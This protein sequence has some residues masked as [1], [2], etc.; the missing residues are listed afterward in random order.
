MRLLYIANARIPTE[1]AHGL[2][3]MQN[4]EALARAGAEVTL[5]TPRRVNTPAL[6]AVADPWAHYGVHP[7]F[8]LQRLPCLD[9][10]WLVGE[11]IALLRRGAFLL[12]VISWLFV[13]TVT[14]LSGRRP[15][16]YYTRDL[17]VAGLVVLLRRGGRLAYE[18]HRISGS[19][20]GR[21]LQARVMR[22]AAALYPVTAAM[23][24]EAGK[25]GATCEQLCVVHDGIRAERFADMPTRETARQQLG[26]NSDRF[27]VGYVGRLQ[28]MAM[29]KGVGS[30]TKA[31]A[32]EKNMAI[33][34]VGGPEER[35][36]E[37]RNLWHACGRSDDDFLV[38]GQVNP[39][40]VPLHLA[41]FDVCA[42]PFPWTEHFAWYAS[43]VKLFEYMSSGRPLVA[44]DLPAVAEVVR[45]EEHAL[46]VPPDDIPAL[47][48]ALLRLQEDA[49]LRQR[50]ACNA[51]EEVMQRYTWAHRARRILRHLARR[52]GFAVMP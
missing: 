29:D 37:L 33:A 31:V 19:G 26:W 40:A 5:Q 27:V 13:L 15:D 25:L 43:P 23:A 18:P 49:A 3:I 4:C 9:L 6:R 48:E 44:T 30:L 7:C 24:R 17:P 45:H 1:K 10:Q 22:H 50:L 42:M 39:E 32:P 12:Q 2:Q 34:L 46:L 47:R 28:T 52:T 20:A 14:L 38:A 41:A 21:W 8:T 35:V 51:R 16:V 36:R 11:R